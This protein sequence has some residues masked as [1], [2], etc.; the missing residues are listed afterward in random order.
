ML[1]YLPTTSLDHL[2]GKE[3]NRR[4]TEWQLYHDCM[5]HMLRPLVDAG[6]SGVDILCCDGRTRKVFPIL[7]AYIADYPEQCLVACTKGR[8]CP[9][10]LAG[11]NKLG[12]NEDFDARDQHRTTQI[13]ER[14]AAGKFTS[15][16]DN[17]GLRP[18]FNPFWTDLPHC[19]IFSCF[20]PDILHQLHKGVFKEHLL[21]WITQ[22]VG[23]DEIDERYKCMPSYPALRDFDKGIS[24]LS[25]CTGVEFKQMQRVFVGL[26]ASSAQTKAVRAARAL[27][28]FT[29]LSQYQSHTTSSLRQLEAALEEF[30]A[31]KDIF[32]ST[33]IREHFNI[34][35]IHSMRHYVEMIKS[36]GSADGFNTELPERLHIDYAKVAYNASNKKVFFAQMTTWLTRQDK[37]HRFDKFLDWRHRD[38]V[39]KLRAARIE[40]ENGEVAPEIE[41]ESDSSASESIDSATPFTSGPNN[42]PSP[43]SLAVTAPFPTMRVCDI[44]RNHKAPQF[45]V[46]LSD[47]I[48]LHV[49]ECRRPPQEMDVLAVYKQAKVLLKSI[50]QVSDKK[51]A[52]TIRAV[53]EDPKTP[54]HAGNPER[55]DPVILRRVVENDSAAGTALE[56]KL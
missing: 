56:G 11:A 7:A 3:E 39:K 29:Y 27:L 24:I 48:R 47:F 16:F 52:N 14:K 44:I 51:R 45:L 36:R 8:R 53:P 5:R 33:G 2:F 13:L 26:L 19:D 50:P 34:P 55:F 12:E 20:T 17:E 6:K 37:M 54:G 30:H 22:L 40:L 9:K 31:N 49:P 42:S 15:A 32:I 23:A 46:C 41:N 10:C 18:V 4:H 38:T 1:G 21:N 35:K 43:Y 28:E 25:Q